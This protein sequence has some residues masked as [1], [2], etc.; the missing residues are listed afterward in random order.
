MPRAVAQRQSIGPH[1]A[2]IC[3]TRTRP[4]A[5]ALPWYTLPHESAMHILLTG[6]SGLIGS[7]VL[8]HLVQESHQITAVDI[9]PPREAIPLGVTFQLVDLTD[10]L[11]VDQ[12]FAGS[13]YDGVIHLGA[14]PAPTGLDER[15]VHNVN[16]TSNYNVIRTA[17]DK[18]IT[19]IVQASSV[20]AVG[21]TY[22]HAEHRTFQGVEL[23]LTETSPYLGEDGYAVSKE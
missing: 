4:E 22:T 18:G 6:A 17:A 5:P 10:V 7:Y 1:R 8:T 14:I 9:V 15:V 20:N 13:A 21:L 12:L 3:T 11:A 16:V 23:P 2:E 19:R